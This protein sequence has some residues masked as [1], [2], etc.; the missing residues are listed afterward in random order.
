MISA[1]SLDVFHS[2]LHPSYALRCQRDGRK[3]VLY[4]VDTQDSDGKIIM[5]AAV[6]GHLLGSAD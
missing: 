1:R 2:A 4:R 5:P 6:P 3:T